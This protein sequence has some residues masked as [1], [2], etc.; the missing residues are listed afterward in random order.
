MAAQLVQLF[1]RFAGRKESLQ[2]VVFPVA[3]VV[4][5]IGFYAEDYF[6]SDETRQKVSRVGERHQFGTCHC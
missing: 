2:L 5:A 3:A 6:T 1:A 4:G